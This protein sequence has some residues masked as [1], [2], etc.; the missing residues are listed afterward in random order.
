MKAITKIV[1]GGVYMAGAIIIV[2]G[3]GILH[4]AIDLKTRG[5]EISLKEAIRLAAGANGVNL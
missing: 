1:L 4:E 5:R 3:V 2:N